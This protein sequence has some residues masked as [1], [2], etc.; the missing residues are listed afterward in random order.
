MCIINYE[1]FYRE[2]DNADV[3]VLVWCK[4][5]HSAAVRHPHM[6]GWVDADSEGKVQSV[7]VKRPLSNPKNDPMIVGNF[8]FKK[9]EYFKS[10]VERMRSRNA[11]INEEFYIDEC[12][13]DAVALGL[14]C[15]LFEV[16]Q[17]ISWGTPSELR[18]FEYWQSCFH[19]WSSHPYRL[20][21]DKTVQ[22]YQIE[23]LEKQAKSFTHG[24][25]F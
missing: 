4:R 21:N 25:K 2:I 12:I 5:G 24:I 10:A 23:H 3:D 16:E 1:K 13:N 11:K 15:V 14:T 9:I 22:Q 20:E 8:T 17:F 19:K 7:L 6:F 18:A